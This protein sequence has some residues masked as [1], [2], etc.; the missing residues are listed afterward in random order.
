M[1]GDLR[2]RSNYERL[3]RT[4]MKT[5]ATIVIEKVLAA[6][7]NGMDRKE[8]TQL[9]LEAMNTPGL[10]PEQLALLTS[11]WLEATTGKKEKSFDFVDLCIQGGGCSGK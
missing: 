11:I 2:Y 7:R 10:T 8:L 9:V 4:T 5:Q 3:S 1:N 6:K